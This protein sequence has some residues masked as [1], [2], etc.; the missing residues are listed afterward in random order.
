MSLRIFWGTPITTLARFWFGGMGSIA[1]ARMAKESPRGA[2]RGA[3]SAGR[4]GLELGIRG[5]IDWARARPLVDR[6]LGL[7][8]LGYPGGLS[9][10]ARARLSG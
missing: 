1:W 9:P 2:R 5:S 10:R 4:L 3:E 7:G 8:L 6:G